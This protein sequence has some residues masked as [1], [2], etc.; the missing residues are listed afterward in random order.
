VRPEENTRLFYIQPRTGV[1]ISMAH[2]KLPLP[3]PFEEV[4]QRHERD[5]MRYLIR[6]S[7][8]LDDAADLFQETW[9]RA[10]RAY[11]RLQPE[12]NVRPWLYAIA[13]NLCRKRACDCTRRLRVISAGS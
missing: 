8:D 2:E 3:L 1:S 4:I 7:G 6:V 11:P 9:L 13:P 10:Y 12:S 5:I